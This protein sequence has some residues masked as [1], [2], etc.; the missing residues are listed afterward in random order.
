MWLV[1]YPCE[2]QVAG[3]SSFVAAVAEALPSAFDVEAASLEE[4]ERPD[5]ASQAP[6]GKTLLG[7]LWDQALSHCCFQEL[8]EAGVEVHQQKAALVACG[9][10]FLLGTSWLGVGPSLVLLVGQLPSAQASWETCEVPLPEQNVL[11]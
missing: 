3:P 8:Q 10:A 11:D 7:L 5:L 2:V 9:Q 6:V 4:D 1:S